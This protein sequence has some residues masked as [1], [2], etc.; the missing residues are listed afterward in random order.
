MISKNSKSVLVLPFSRLRLKHVPLVGGKNASLGEMIHALEP[1]GIPIP[2]GFATTAAAYWKFVDANKLRPLIKKTLRGLNV[3]DASDVNRRARAIREAFLAA[4]V[5][6]DLQKKIIQSYHDLG[7]R[8]RTPNPD[9]AVRSSATAE[10][11]PTASF[12]GQQESYLHIQGEQ[13]VLDAWRKCVASLFTDRAVV[14][15]EEQ[16]FNHLKVALSVGVQQMIRSD[17]GSA[18]VIF[19]IDTETGFKDVVVINAA[20]GLGESV[21]QG[22]VNP[23]QYIV[24]KPTLSEGFCSI[25]EHRIGDKVTRIVYRGSSTLEEKTP[26]VLRV[27][28]V[29]DDKDICKLARWAVEIEKYYSKQAGYHKPMDIEWAKDGKTGKLFIVQARP[30][31][32]ASQKSRNFLEVYRLKTSTKPWL[33]GVAVGHKIGAGKARVLQG[34]K[35]M[36]QFR[37][38]EVLVAHMTDPDWVPIM[39]KAAAIVTESGGRTCHAAIVSRELGVPCVV[40]IAN[41]ARFIKTGQV[42]TVSAAQGEEGFVYKGKLEFEIKHQTLRRPRKLKTKVMAIVGDPDAAFKQAAL[43]VDGVGLARME[44]ILNQAVKIHPMALIRP[45]RVKDS[46]ARK[47]INELTAGFKD[48]KE[49]FVSTLAEGIGKLAA[50]FYPRPVIVRTSDFKTN[51]YAN[52]LGGSYFEPK[53]DNPM[54]GWRGASRYY[55]PSYEPAFKLECKAIKRVRKEMGLKN[56][57]VMIPFCRTVAEGQKVLKTMS[58]YGLRR[59]QDGLQVYMMVEI[60]S[61]VILAK[62]FAK[63][64]DGFSIGSNDLTQ[65]ALGVDRDSALVSHLYSERNEAVT[66]LIKSVIASAK[67]SKTKIGICGQAPSDYPEFAKFLVRQKIDS[68]SLNPDSV[69][70]MMRK[71]KN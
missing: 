9:V 2:D 37:E 44:F 56:L 51:E 65:L 31:T 63:L 60:P 8:L 61:N 71:L 3:K 38:G 13:A 68:I 17:V 24:H 35:Q 49:Y 11:L 1:R 21:V 6:K 19:T 57:L 16:G 33:K 55:D 29:L 34:A 41:A 58:K 45:E 15:R 7:K 20:Y 59:G 70:P 62:E 36:Q 27:K 40:G 18:G 30:E 14:Y 53:E 5:P 66:S 12:A 32:V 52:L 10:D 42:I 67:I 26:E 47:Q 23:D 46:K 43:P 50:A 54:I 39:R 4:E 48:K 25:V 64:F 28:R 69:I 22:K